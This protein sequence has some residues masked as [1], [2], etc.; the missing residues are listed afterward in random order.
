[1]SILAKIS[2][3]AAITALSLFTCAV[4]G[5]AL[6]WYTLPISSLKVASGNAQKPDAAFVLPSPPPARDEMPDT[7][8]V[9]FRVWE[10]TARQPLPPRKEPLTAPGWKIVGV[11]L[12]GNE[13][14]VLFLYDKKSAIEIRKEGEELPGGAKIVQISQEYLRIFLN[15][16]FMKLSLLKQ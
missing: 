7:D 10:M 6:G 5:A 16:Q 12:V 14:N 1:M 15:G 11:T 3:N 2:R 9:D 4:S 8:L 13:K